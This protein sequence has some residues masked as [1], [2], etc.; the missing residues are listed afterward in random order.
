MRFVTDILHRVRSSSD[1][2]EP[3]VPTCSSERE[4]DDGIRESHRGEE[5]TAR[6]SQSED[7]INV[8]E[9]IP[10]NYEVDANLDV[11]SFDMKIMSFRAGG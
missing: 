7:G 2:S 8:I 6:L 3:R 1:E 11:D 5:E 10:R 9:G 4:I